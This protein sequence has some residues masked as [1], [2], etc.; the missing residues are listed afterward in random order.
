MLCNA[1]KIGMPGYRDSLKI[2]KVLFK[3]K[4]RSFSLPIYL[5][6]LIV[7]EDSFFNIDNPCFIQRKKM[8]SE[9]NTTTLIH[10]TMLTLFSS[11]YDLWWSILA[12]FLLAKRAHLLLVTFVPSGLMYR[13]FEA[14][15]NDSRLSYDYCR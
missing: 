9:R 1:Q 8:F 6:L 13:N 10:A 5:V 4:F 11:H 15:F 7:T 14:V 3:Q 12:C 2:M